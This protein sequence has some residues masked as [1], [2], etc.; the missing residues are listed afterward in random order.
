MTR[1][2]GDKVDRSALAYFVGSC[3]AG[4]TAGYFGHPLVHANSDAVTVIVTLFSILAGFVVAI[5]TLIG[6]PAVLERH[7]WRAHEMI[8]KTVVARLTRQKW[9]FVLYLCTLGALFVSTL[10]AKASPHLAPYFEA[11]YLA[12]AVTSFLLSLRLPSALLR[13]Q[14]D[15]HDEAIRRKQASEGLRTE[16]Q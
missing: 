2:N 14:Q 9:L 11:T 10:V 15:R 12:L 5:M 13:I 1:P 8:R 16:Q 6:D 7:N 3:L 4:A